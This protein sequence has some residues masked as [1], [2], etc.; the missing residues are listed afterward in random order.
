MKIY[1][2]VPYAESIVISKK[3]TAQNAIVK[4]FD[5]IKQEC[6][7][8]WEYHST[9]PVKITRKLSKFKK[10]EESYN[11]FIFVKEVKEPSLPTE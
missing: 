6:V 4:F 9:S 8:G 3:E 5:V 1:K 10:R 7:D 11:A 2:V